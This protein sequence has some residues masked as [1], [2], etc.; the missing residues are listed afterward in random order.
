MRRPLYW[1]VPPAQPSPLRPVHLAV[2]RWP[3]V[4]GTGDDGLQPLHQLLQQDRGAQARGGVGGEE[5]EGRA[6]FGI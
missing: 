1:L 2:L 6:V 3:E 5:W 4:L